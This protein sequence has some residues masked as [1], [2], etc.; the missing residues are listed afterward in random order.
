MSYTELAE[1]RRITT[2]SAIR[3][4]LR[5]GWRRQ[6]DNQGVMRALVP[7]Q[8][9][10]PARNF[11][12]DSHL[13]QAI[14]TL[15]ATIAV[16]RE[17]AEVAEH[18]AEIERERANRAEVARRAEYSRAD[19]LRERIDHLRADLAEAEAAMEMTR[20]EAREAAQVAEALRE[21]DARWRSLGRV[22]RIREVWRNQ[23]PTG[24][25]GEN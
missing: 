14:A 10:E 25:A 15:E 4:V 18:A 12:P 1:A 5:R 6:Q 3:L 23:R 11:E 13:I 17:R 8:W 19:L 16:L 2:P 7:A 24:A 20:Y 21:E 22:A 9:M